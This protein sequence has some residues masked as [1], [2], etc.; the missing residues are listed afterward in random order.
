MANE[1]KPDTNHSQFF[2]T[3]DA[4]EYL[5]G[6]HT[7]FG[8]VVGN[9]LFNVLKMGD[10]QT[11]SNDHPIYPPCIRS[12][13]IVTNPFPDIIP[14]YNSNHTLNSR[15]IKKEE[16]TTKKKEVK[17]PKQVKNNNLLSFGDD[18]EDE[19]FG[20]SIVSFQQASGIVKKEELISQ[21]PAQKKED[22]EWVKKMKQK[23]AEKESA[24]ANSNTVQENTKPVEEEKEEVKE[25]STEEK[26]KEKVK[27]KIRE[28]KK[29]AKEV[30]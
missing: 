29:K 16:V 8:K 5:Y 11:D 10:L 25:I 21:T 17:R 20:S 23:L 3:L 12:V 4:T 7:I 2:I 9:T 26:V 27:E 28:M 19:G 14:R 13:S 15:E 6:K 1:N 22:S 18:D 24:K 30:E